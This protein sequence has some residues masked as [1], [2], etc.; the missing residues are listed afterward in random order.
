MLL[1]GSI[2][3][4]QASLKISHSTFDHLHTQGIAYSCL[5]NS[6]G[7]KDHLFPSIL[8]HLLFQPSCLC[9]AIKHSR[10]PP[11]SNSLWLPLLEVVMFFIFLPLI[12]VGSCT[13]VLCEPQLY[14]LVSDL[15]SKHPCGSNPR[16]DTGLSPQQ[17][18]LSLCDFPPLRRV[19]L[20]LYEVSLAFLLM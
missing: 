20:F 7:P 12:S 15:C 16:S 19:S 5:S 17:P 13:H 18:C 1:F 10:Q 9:S 4:A 11:A 14:F 2:A 6:S 8:L 3:Q